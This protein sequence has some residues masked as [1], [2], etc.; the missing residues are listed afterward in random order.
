MAKCLILLTL[1][2][3]FLS[4]PGGAADD[5]WQWRFG[6]YGGESYFGTETDASDDCDQSDSL[7]ATSGFI[8]IATYHQQETG[9]W[10]GPSGFYSCD[11]RS[12]LPA[13]PGAVSYT[14]LTLPTT[15]YV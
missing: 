6:P 8:N 1:L 15:P 11:L 9:N 13:D 10:T 2:A 12:P 14:H 3:L 7:L 4:S 5:A